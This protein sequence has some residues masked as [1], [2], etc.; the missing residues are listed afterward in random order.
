MKQSPSWE[1]D[2]RSASQIPPP[3]VK[4]KSSLQ[5]SQ[6]STTAPHP[7]PDESSP[8]I[9]QYY[10]DLIKIRFNITFPSTIRY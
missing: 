8:Y 1:T 9:L 2:S 10:L 3:L 5:C 6:E 7:E 4:T